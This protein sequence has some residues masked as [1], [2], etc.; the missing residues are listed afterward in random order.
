MA[1]YEYYCRECDAEETIEQPMADP[2]VPPVCEAHGEMVQDYSFGIRKVFGVGS[3]PN[4]TIK[5]KRKT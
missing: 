4:R 1:V 5:S 3:S 2:L